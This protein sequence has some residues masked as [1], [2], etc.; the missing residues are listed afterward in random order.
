M[1]S[2]LSR[3]ITGKV[4]TYVHMTVL[5]AVTVYGVHVYQQWRCLQGVTKTSSILL[6]TNAYQAT[7]YKQTTTDSHNK[8][9]H[10]GSHDAEVQVAQVCAHIRT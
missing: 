2:F 4:R 1:C 3:V 8:S 6:A 5:Y 9:P 10:G 7:V